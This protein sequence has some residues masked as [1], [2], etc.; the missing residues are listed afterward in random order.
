MKYKAV[1]IDDEPLAI[2]VIELFLNRFPNFEIVKTFSDSVVA[3]QFLKINNN[4]DIVF[5]DIAMPEISGIELI[6]LHQNETFYVITTSFSE[7]AVESFDLNVLDYL[8]KP[9]SFERFS[10]T[11]DRFKKTQIKNSNF[12]EEPSFFVK[13][14][15]DYI[16][17]LIKDID[18]IEGL[19]DYAKIVSGKNFCLALKT[20]KSIE[21]KLQPYNFIRIH[22][23]FIVP[24]DKIS[25]Y[26]GKSVLI[27]NNEIPV[28]NSYRVNLKTFLLN[29]KL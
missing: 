10:K 17:I 28:G 26:N 21:K 12:K 25:Q 6:K 20:L 29:H 27:N 24:L 18:Y 15:D 23:S 14:S 8:L 1:I 16:K 13:D 3:F 11:I 7:F 19:K 2:N 4:I 9:I 22:K 5:T